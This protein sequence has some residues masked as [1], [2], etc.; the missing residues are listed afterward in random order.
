[1]AKPTVRVRVEGLRELNAAL[2]ELP[3]ATGRNVLKRTAEKA[4][5]PFIEMARQLVPVLS[6]RLKNSLKI[7]TRLSR[8]QASLARKEKKSYL[9]MYAGA[10]ALPH[11]HLVEF[12]TKNIKGAVRSSKGLPAQPFMR[13]A[14]DQTKNRV[15]E[16]TKTELG[17]EI[18]IAAKRIAKKTARFA[19]KKIGNI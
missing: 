14:W 7:S 2:S 19:R 3:K 13:P 10:S 4:L 18:D 6:G 11:A 12:G 15:L 1:M 5:K 8:R 17:K 16:I 9:E